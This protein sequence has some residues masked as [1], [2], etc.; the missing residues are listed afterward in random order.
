MA[1]EWGCTDFVNPKA[2][3]PALCVSMQRMNGLPCGALGGTQLERAEIV[4]RTP[5]PLCL[6]TCMVLDRAVA[7]ETQARASGC[8]DCTTS[9]ARSLAFCACM[10]CLHAC[11]CVTLSDT[12]TRVRLP[13]SHTPYHV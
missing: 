7:S 3:N 2:R 1:R 4:M 10:E 8:T 11:P 12:R 13:A 9:K 5:P 6:H